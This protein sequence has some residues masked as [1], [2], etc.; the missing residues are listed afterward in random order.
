MERLT[1]LSVDTHVLGRA[2]LAID[3]RPYELATDPGAP[4]TDRGHFLW[5]VPVFG[6]QDRKR[7]PICGRPRNETE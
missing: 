4:L 3:E 2:E 6:D 5:R 7:D 1:L